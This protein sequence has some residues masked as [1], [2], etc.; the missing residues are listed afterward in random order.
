MEIK[1]ITEK[2][3]WGSIKRIREK[4]EDEEGKHVKVGKKVRERKEEGKVLK[5]RN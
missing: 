3:R 4:R 1:R 2:R 5:R